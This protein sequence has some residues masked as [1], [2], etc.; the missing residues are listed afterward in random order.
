MAVVAVVALDLGAIRAW[1][2]NYP[3]AEREQ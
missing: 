3:E 1:S 2:S